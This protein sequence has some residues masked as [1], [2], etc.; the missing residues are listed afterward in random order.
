LLGSD[1]RG[2]V[3]KLPFEIFVDVNSH[4]FHLVADPGAEIDGTLVV[5]R[6]YRVVV[7][8]HYALACAL[9]LFVDVTLVPRPVVEFLGND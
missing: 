9:A 4:S 3:Q 2:K 6:F 7:E 5:G 8:I 1:K